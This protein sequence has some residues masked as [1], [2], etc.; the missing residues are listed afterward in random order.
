MTSYLK[1]IAVPVNKLL[2]HFVGGFR[3]IENGLGTDET[4]ICETPVRRSRSEAIADAIVFLRQ[5]A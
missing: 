1:P 5:A 4:L 3:V 2:G